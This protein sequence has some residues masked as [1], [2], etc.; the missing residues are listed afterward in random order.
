LVLGSELPIVIDADG[1]NAYQGDAD[2][3]PP[4]RSLALTPHP[5]EAARLLGCAA[6]DIQKSRLDSVRKLAAQTDA[7]VLLKGHRTLVCN[8]AGHVFINLTGN[9]GLA[10]GGSGD[11]L[12]GVVGALIN[13]LPVDVALRVAAHLHGLAGDLAVEN[14]GQTSLMATDVIRGLPKALLRLGAA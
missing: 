6:R 7:S 3:F 14:I 5:G 1:L 11:V 12:T 13:R 9:P 8:P 2:A 10:T 4:K